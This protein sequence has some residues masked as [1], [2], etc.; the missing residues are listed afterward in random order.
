MRTYVRLWS[1]VRRA[2]SET[3]AEEKN[4]LDAPVKRYV[5]G[6]LEGRGDTPD[7]PLRILLQ[8]GDHVG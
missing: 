4:P 3:F 6:C 8:I 2:N 7:R 5:T 1:P